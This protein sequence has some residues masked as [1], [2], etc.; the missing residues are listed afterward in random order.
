MSSLAEG[1]LDIKKYQSLGGCRKKN[2]IWKVADTLFE[3]NVRGNI[4]DVN[5]ASP[6]IFARSEAVFNSRY[7]F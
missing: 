1:N 6:I 3:G 5:R 2:H 4:S 7:F